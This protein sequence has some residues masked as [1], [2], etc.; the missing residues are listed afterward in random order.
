MQLYSRWNIAMRSG[1][2]PCG[3]GWYI[4]PPEFW[5]RQLRETLGK[6]LPNK[7]SEDVD[8][9]GSGNGEMAPSP[10]R[11]GPR[12][13]GRYSNSIRKSIE[14]GAGSA[15]EQ[16]EADSSDIR[17]LIEQSPERPQSINE[18]KSS[19]PSLPQDSGR[20][21]TRKRRSLPVED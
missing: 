6:E 18:I 5:E 19:K 4:I 16:Q 9:S 20:T 10:S 11:G 7:A 15:A 12:G 13:P 2:S 8:A 17:P 14:D 21:R 1:A 3:V